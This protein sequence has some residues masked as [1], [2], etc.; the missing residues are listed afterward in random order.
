[1]AARP[2]STYCRA[3]N[4]IQ[5]VHQRKATFCLGLAGLRAK[6]YA[7]NLAGAAFLW[8]LFAPCFYAEAA[9]VMKKCAQRPPR[10]YREG[11]RIDQGPIKIE[12]WV[13]W[14]FPRI[15]GSANCYPN[16]DP[17]LQ[18]WPPS[19]HDARFRLPK[20]RFRIFRAQTG[21][22]GLNLDLQGSIWASSAQF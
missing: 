21:P 1:M 14:V 15:S 2:E 13:C 18:I 9:P 8:F 5:A 16:H 3:R 11:P 20:H 10:K 22:P 6:Q 4:E 12:I 19:L 17:R 7:T